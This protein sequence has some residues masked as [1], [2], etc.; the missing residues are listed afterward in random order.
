MGKFLNFIKK[1]AD[2]FILSVMSLLLFCALIVCASA[3]WAGIR[4]GLSICGTLGVAT[5]EPMLLILLYNEIKD[6]I[7]R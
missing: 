1:W 5:V 3:I 4:V 6:N 2:T 7:G